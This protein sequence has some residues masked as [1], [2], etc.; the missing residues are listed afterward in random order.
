LAWESGSFGTPGR[1]NG[2]STDNE[3]LEQ[4]NVALLA[5]NHW[6]QN[7]N[8][9]MLVMIKNAADVLEEYEK[10][11]DLIRVELNKTKQVYSDLHLKLTEAF[12]DRRPGLHNTE[13]RPAD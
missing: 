3:K 1:R 6:L 13:S 4:E 12:D 8:D 2:M 5:R 9:K 11:V 10:Q 7:V